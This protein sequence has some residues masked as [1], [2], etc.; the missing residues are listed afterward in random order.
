SGGLRPGPCAGIPSRDPQT[1]LGSC[2]NVAALAGSIQRGCD[3]LLA[4]PSD[5]GRRLQVLRPGYLREP[6]GDASVR[7]RAVSRWRGDQGA[8][9]GRCAVLRRVHSAP[10][11]ARPSGAR[12]HGVTCVTAVPVTK[13]TCR[14]VTSDTRVRTARGHDAERVAVQ[15]CGARAVR[16]GEPGGGEEGFSQ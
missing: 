16:G 15:P 11:P 14:L 9:G 8:R 6:R 13:V 10:G 2:P 7:A 12:R 5:G 1:D 4:L 3:G